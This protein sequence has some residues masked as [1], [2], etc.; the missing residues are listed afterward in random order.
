MIYQFNTPNNLHM[1]QPKPDIT[2]YELALCLPVL[3]S[4][5]FYKVEGL[6]DEARRHFVSLHVKEFVAEEVHLDGGS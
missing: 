4:D 2:T 1:W 6:P 3:L 5:Y